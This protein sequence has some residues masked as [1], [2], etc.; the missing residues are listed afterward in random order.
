MVFLFLGLPALWDKLFSI[1]VG[2]VIIMIALSFKPAVRSIS[3][4]HSTY[5]EH[6]TT[7]GSRNM[8]S[9]SSVSTDTATDSAPITNTDSTTIS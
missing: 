3:V 5:K 7:P 6:K 4:G 8:S 1:G 2:F 9:G